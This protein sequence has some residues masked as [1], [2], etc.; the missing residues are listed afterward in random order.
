[1]SFLELKLPDISPLQGVKILVPMNQHA[2]AV[3]E[4][5][6]FVVMILTHAQHAFVDRLGEG[7]CYRQV[8]NLAKFLLKHVTATFPKMMVGG[9]HLNVIFFIFFKDADFLEFQ[10]RYRNHNKY[11]I[12]IYTVY[13]YNN[14]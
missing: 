4:I 6:H 7:T 5:I 9:N 13:I 8:M 10:A 1:M 11:N 12:Y 3:N 14:I 2:L